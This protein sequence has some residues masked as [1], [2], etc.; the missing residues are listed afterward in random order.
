MNTGSRSASTKPEFEPT[1]VGTSGHD[2]TFAINQ[3]FA[4]A[5]QLDEEDRGLASQMVRMLGR[6]CKCLIS[7]LAEAREE[8]AELKAGVKSSRGREKASAAGSL[9]AVA[10]MGLPGKTHKHKYDEAG[11]CQGWTQGNGKDEPC[12]A[13]RQRKPKGAGKNGAGAERGELGAVTP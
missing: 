10:G 9:P 4:L 8:L 11:V 13:R 3:A 1:D 7:D 6:F 2:Q 5:N 12:M